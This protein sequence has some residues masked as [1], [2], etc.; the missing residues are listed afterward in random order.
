MFSQEGGSV[1]A[2]IDEDM[3]PSAQAHPQPTKLEPQQD[4]RSND[5]TR[6]DSIFRR[7]CRKEMKPK[8]GK[9]WRDH[10]NVVNE[11]R[12]VLDERLLDE[13]ARSLSSMLRAGEQSY[14][15][16]ARLVAGQQ[17][18]D[19][20][21]THLQV[22]SNSNDDDTRAVQHYITDR[23]VP[24]TCFGP[25]H[26]VGFNSKQ[27][28]YGFDRRRVRKPNICLRSHVILVIVALVILLLL[29]YTLHH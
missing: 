20:S 24:S 27:F 3:H 17:T 11:A 29:D 6:R 26:M 8:C 21:Q 13:R 22:S 4:A 15:G 2:Q 9:Q 5:I 7:R 14:G 18:D 12:L 16:G 23:T 25:D 1:G 19:V 10:P 28:P